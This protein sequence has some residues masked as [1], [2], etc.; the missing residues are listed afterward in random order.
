MGK[1]PFSLGRPSSRCRHKRVAELPPQATD[2]AASPANLNDGGGTIFKPKKKAGGARLWM[3][4][5]RLGRSEFIE[6]DRSAVIK[7]A[8]IP[9]RDLRILGPVFSYSSN[10]LVSTLLPQDLS[11]ILLPQKFLLQETLESI[12]YTYLPALRSYYA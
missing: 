4:F 6:L 7:R 11:S 12:E 3:R 9:A 10:V 5:D 1:G 2:G 8:A